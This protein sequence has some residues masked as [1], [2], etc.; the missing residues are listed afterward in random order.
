MTQR[1]GAWAMVA[2]LWVVVLLNY[3]DRQVIFSLFP[4]LRSDLNLSDAQLGLVSSAFLWVYALASPLA[5]Y[6]S[7]RLGHRRLVLFSLLVWSVVTALTGLA[8]NFGELVL[9]RAAM[10]LSEACYIP[11]ALTLIAGHHPEATRARAVGFHQSGIYFG[12]VIGGM[13]GGWMGEHYGWRPVFYLLGAAGIAYGL[14]LTRVL[15]AP[16]NPLPSS[17]ES[18]WRAASALLRVPGFKIVLTVF[19]VTSLANWLVYTWLPLFLFERFSLSLTSAGFAATFYVQIMAVVGIAA[20]GWVSDRWTPSQP[21][22]RIWVQAI[23]LAVAGPF[24]ILSGLASTPLVLYL[25]LVA[26]GLGRGV[27]DSNIM[28]VL[29]R[30]VGDNR[31][32]TG[33]GLLNFAGVM[34]G[35]LAAY[36]AGLVKSTVGLAGAMQIAGALVLICAAVILAIP[37]PPA[38]EPQEV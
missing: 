11:A 35:G 31:R 1:R 10:G 32:A 21:K 7:D 3:L 2:L 17:Q 18:F 14:L 27:Y 15:R 24:L 26:F 12:I 16:A 19:A 30:L 34:T 33:Y 4:L 28:P 37:Q 23:G 38:Q 9:A 36:G 6:L 5:G 29:C 22:A 13:G 20:G 25:A 8:R